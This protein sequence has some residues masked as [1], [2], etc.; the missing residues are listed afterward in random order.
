MPKRN[1][2]PSIWTVHN[3]GA[4]TSFDF[5]TYYAWAELD[6]KARYWFDTYQYTDVNECEQCVI[7]L[8]P[9]IS[10]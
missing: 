10:R 7:D 5:G 3:I 1:R 4:K 2:W 6:G 9:S 8:D